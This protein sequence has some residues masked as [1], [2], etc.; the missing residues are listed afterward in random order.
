MKT[1]SHCPQCGAINQVQHCSYCDS[2]L[3][4]PLSEIEDIRAEVRKLEQEIGDKSRALYRRLLKLENEVQIHESPAQESK[5]EVAYGPPKI[6]PPINSPK[7]VEKKVPISQHTH[8]SSYSTNQQP[9]SNHSSTSEA[10]AKPSSPKELPL[11]LQFLLAP[12]SG[13]FSYAKSLFKH[14]KEEGRLPVFFLSLG[15]IIAILFGLGYL[16]QLGLGYFLDIL[17]AKSLEAI[18]IVCALSGASLLLGLGIRFSR[19]E[20]KYRDF[21]SALLGLAIGSYYLIFY[22]LPQSQNFPLFSQGWIS[23]LLVATT[24]SLGSF[25]AL[26]HEARILAI[27]SYLGAALIPVFIQGVFLGEFYLIFL[28]LLTAAQLFIAN[29]IDWRPLKAISLLLVILI[30]EWLVFAAPENFSPALLLIALHGF[31]YLFLGT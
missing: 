29:R 17:S 31:A 11:F 6:L 19:K 3:V 1:H 16:M 4:L 7:T 21:S 24:A 22:F 8:T 20:P 15:G 26:K 30:I 14:Y 9:I 13:I 23:L 25:L 12:L 18:K 2:L 27:V 5:K 28:F 10:K